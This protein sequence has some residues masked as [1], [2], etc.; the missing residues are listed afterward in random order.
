MDTVKV[1]EHIIRISEPTIS[2]NE[3]WQGLVNSVRN[4]EKFV[5]HMEGSRILSEELSDVGT[6][7]HREIDFGNFRLRDRVILRENESLLTMVDAGANWK[8]SSFLIRI[9][10]PEVGVLFLRFV[11]EEE[12]GGEALPDM[13]V[14]LR[15]RAYEAKDHHLVEQVLNEIAAK[16][17]R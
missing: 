4:P 11:Y 15:R 10:E 12:N 7:L 1:H 5:E 9:E 2:R 17:S 8:A 16:A 14:Q 6:V 13:F 3:L